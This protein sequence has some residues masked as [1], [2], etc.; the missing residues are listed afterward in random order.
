VQLQGD[1]ILSDEQVV[2][3][4]AS[5]TGRNCRAQLLH[6]TH[7]VHD[8]SLSPKELAPHA[9]ISRAGTSKSMHAVSPLLQALRSF[10]C[11][12]SRWSASNQLRRRQ[13][14][15]PYGPLGA[16]SSSPWRS[17]SIDGMLRAAAALPHNAAPSMPMVGSGSAGTQVARA[18]AVGLRDLVSTMAA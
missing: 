11:D 7:K 4:V 16:A 6:D 17:S 12:A 15:S 1:K 13:K 10:R 18:V 14:A 5:R 9:Y 3:V 8:P 2:V